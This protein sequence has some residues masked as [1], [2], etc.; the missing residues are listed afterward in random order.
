[1]YIRIIATQNPEPLLHTQKLGKRTNK[2]RLGLQEFLKI[3]C[4]SKDLRRE[5]QKE[6]ITARSL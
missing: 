5:R 1:V 4:I 3:G 2:T 6:K